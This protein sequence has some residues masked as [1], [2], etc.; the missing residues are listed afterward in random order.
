VV[1]WWCRVNCLF[2]FR[3]LEALM[4]GTSVSVMQLISQSQ[5]L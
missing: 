5:M 4:A 1:L 2:P 3:C